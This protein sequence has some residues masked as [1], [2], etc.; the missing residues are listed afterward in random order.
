MTLI[1]TYTSLVEEELHALHFKQEPVNLYDPLGYILSLGGK[2]LRPAMLL[3]GNALFGGKP[4]EALKPALGIEFFHNFSLIHDDI[5]DKASL[6][7]G[8]ATVHKK[9]NENVGILSGDAMLVKAY[10]YISH[11]APEHLPAVLACF[12]ETAME[13]C[14]GQQYDM[15]FESQAVVTEEEYIRMIR[16]KTSVL[17]GAALKIGAITA[18]ATQKEQ[19][20]I[21]DFG[22]NI[23]I[24]FQIQDD[25]LDSFGD[26]DKF[27]KK[28]GGDILNNKQT[29]LMIAVK[30]LADGPER[31]QLASTPQLDD[32]DKVE[33]VKEI[34]EIT[35]ALAYAETKREAYYQR[36]L[37]A[38]KAID[39]QHPIKEELRYFAQYL[40]QRDK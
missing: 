40:V 24:A 28:V 13:V 2:R 3:A 8:K 14:E 12:S 25:I 26:P 27:G 15:D 37:T 36:S 7:R 4:E 20:L 9:W 6:R 19:Q 29:L 22:V 32:Q 38:L 34:F 16:L 31:L 18:G 35:G 11:V 33:A 30:N 17:L 1:E 21:Y 23:G 10:Q 39:N 5:M